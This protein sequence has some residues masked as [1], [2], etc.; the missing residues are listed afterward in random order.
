MFGSNWTRV[1]VERI[2]ALQCDLHRGDTRALM[3]HPTFRRWRWEGSMRR[4]LIVPMVVILLVSLSV[5]A[6]AGSPK[7]RFDPNDSRLN[8]DV[9]RVVS[10]L[11]NRTL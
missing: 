11:S 10:D 8:T 7:V 2:L 3:C 9:R 5:L 6:E 4:F 1:K